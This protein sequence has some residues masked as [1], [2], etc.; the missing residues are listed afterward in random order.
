[1]TSGQNIVSVYSKNP[2]G[3][4]SNT[5]PRLLWELNPLG[6]WL[7]FGDPAGFHLRP[8]YRPLF[9]QPLFGQNASEKAQ[10]TL[11]LTVTLTLALALT[12]I[13]TLTLTHCISI[14]EWSKPKLAEPEVEV[15]L[16]SKYYT[17]TLY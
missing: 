14:A 13:L 4:T 16:Y 5:S 6:P 12:L 2:Y 15:K 7:V 8:G 17:N 1:M 9:R 3:K 10:L 11:T